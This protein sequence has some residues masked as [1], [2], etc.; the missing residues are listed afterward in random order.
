MATLDT[1]SFAAA[2]K[3]L[4]PQKRIAEI[5][6]RNQPF[7]ASVPKDTNFGGANRVVAARY[8]TPGSASH[9]ASNPF[10]AGG[11][12]VGKYAK[13]TVTRSSDFGSASLTGE[14]IK[15]SQGDQNALISALDSEMKG[16]IH[17]LSRRL[18]VKLFRNYGGA[19]GQVASKS[20]NTLTLTTT[21]DV[22]NFQVGY[23]LVNSTAD[24]TS[25][26]VGSASSVVTA[27]DR[28]AG[29]VTVASGTNFSANDYLFCAGD[30]GLSFYGLG[31]WLPT[32]A[33]TSGDSFFNLDRSA[34]TTR[35]AGVRYSAGAGGPIEETLID[36]CVLVAREGGMID[37][38]LLNPIDWG[39][40][41]KALGSK[42][43]RTEFKTANFG[44]QA[45][46]IM[47]GTGPVKVVADLNC[48]KGYAYGVQLDTWTF[49]SLG[50]APMVFDLDGQQ[51]L[52][53]NGSDSYTVRAGTYGQLYCEAPGYNFVATL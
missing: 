35:L 52:R 29:T 34:D 1:S 18:G 28:T 42:V 43:I 47:T 17:T 7:L 16:L 44:F 53:D 38:V 4:W 3:T 15:A 37:I 9:T 32:T 49:A 27:V 39:N 50:D 10:T 19:I 20:T 24:G 21:A 12:A 30:F 14:V 5:M 48:P 45:L 51:L 46:E 2:L 33:P 40:L 31:S 22:T 25:G 8:A 6:Y 41:V 13:W 23:T 36:A 11:A 26:S